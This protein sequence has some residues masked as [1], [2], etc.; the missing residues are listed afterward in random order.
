[1]KRITV[2][3][4]DDVIKEM[5][6]L[7]QLFARNSGKEYRLDLIQQTENLVKSFKAVDADKANVGQKY[8]KIMKICHMQQLC[9]DL[10]QD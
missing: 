3:G 9:Q 4:Q 1:M 2:E 5:D 6:T 10:G 8:L 7:A